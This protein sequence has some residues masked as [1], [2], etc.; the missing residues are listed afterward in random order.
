MRFPEENSIR[1][2]QHAA[3]TR[4]QHKK[5]QTISPIQFSGENGIEGCI[6]GLRRKQHKKKSVHC[7]Q[8]KTA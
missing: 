8:E 4:K 1:R 5:K 7:F 2:N 3:F 6:T